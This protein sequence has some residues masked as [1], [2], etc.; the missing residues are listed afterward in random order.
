VRLLQ[1]R[2]RFTQDAI[3]REFEDAARP[4]G[5]VP[6]CSIEFDTT[7]KG[8]LTPVAEER[9]S[10]VWYLDASVAVVHAVIPTARFSAETPDLKDRVQQIVQLESHG[11]VDVK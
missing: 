4:A 2:D 10:V 6:P 8:Y 9:Y 3:K 7:R 11:A 1:Q 5:D